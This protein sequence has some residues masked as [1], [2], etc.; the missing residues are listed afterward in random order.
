MKT[1]NVHGGGTTLRAIS[2]KKT[3]ALA[4]CVSLW[5]AGGSVEA[6]TPELCEISRRRN[7]GYGDIYPRHQDAFYH[8]RHME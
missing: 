1:R 2:R 5:T 6:A 8:R 7:G 3:A 4:L